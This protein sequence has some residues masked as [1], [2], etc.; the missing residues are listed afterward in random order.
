M[1]EYD[2]L[3]LMFYTHSITRSLKDGKY[4]LA[5]YSADRAVEI[6]EGM[7]EFD[8]KTLSNVELIELIKS[9]AIEQE[10]REYCSGVQKSSVGI[11]QR[12]FKSRTGRVYHD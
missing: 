5:A 12:V 1:N 11:E 9:A 2:R 6:V 7:K 3:N 8:I 10:N 4:D